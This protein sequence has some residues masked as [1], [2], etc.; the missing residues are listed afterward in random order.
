MEF[1]C[2]LTNGVDDLKTIDP[3]GVLKN[4]STSNDLCFWNGLV[5]SENL[6]RVLVLNLT[7]SGLSGSIS[8]ELSRLTS[9]QTIDLSMNDRS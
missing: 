6:T 8:P 5:C 1:V 3:E 2:N 4:W 9:L 7:S